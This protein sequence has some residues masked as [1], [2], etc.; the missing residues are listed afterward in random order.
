MLWCRAMLF[1]C[2]ECS[3]AGSV[4]AGLMLTS[5]SVY[6]GFMAEVSLQTA[7]WMF[8]HWWWRKTFV[9]SNS[10][11]HI[12]WLPARFGVFLFFTILVYA[13]FCTKKIAAASAVFEQRNLTN[14]DRDCSEV[15]SSH[16]ESASHE[17]LCHPRLELQRS[18]RIQRLRRQKELMGT[19]WCSARCRLG[20]P[21]MPR[22][23]YRYQPTSFSAL[24]QVYPGYIICTWWHEYRRQDIEGKNS[25]AEILSELRQLLASLRR[26]RLRKRSRRLLA[27]VRALGHMLSGFSGS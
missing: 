17:S 24:T 18:R 21:T 22:I 10:K 26:Q 4:Y 7:N 27:K 2:W 12:F 19:F 9:K 8:P 14:V 20:D 5:Y 11:W 3:S 6:C 16:L 15:C 25:H 13:A 1:L 23:F